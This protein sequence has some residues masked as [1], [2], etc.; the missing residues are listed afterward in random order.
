MAGI[1]GVN[2]V[3]PVVPTSTTDVHPSH[4]ARYGKGGWRTVATVEERDAIPAPRREQGMVVVVAADGRRWVLGS[5]LT[6][7]TEDTGGGGASSW[8]DVT[9]KPTT[10]SGFGITDAVTTA[11]ARLTDSREWTAATVEQAEA[12]AGAA[13]TRRAWTAQRVWQAVAAYIASLAPQTFQVRRG[14]DAE[15]LAIVPASGEPIWTTDGKD[16]YVGDGS[17][18]GGVLPGGINDDVQAAL[19]G[20]ATLSPIY[21]PAAFG[22][23]ESATYLRDHETGNTALHY[24]SDDAYRW[25]VTDP[26]FLRDAISAAPTSHAHGNL[27]SDGKVGSTANLPVITGTA[28]ALTVGSFGTGAN[29]FC[30]GNDAR[31]SDSRTPTAHASTHQPGGADFVAP[32][33]TSPTSLGANQ[34]DYA[35][36]NAD[37]VR[38]TS[39]AAYD[40]TGF[41]A[42]ATARTVLLVNIGSFDLT[43]KHQSTSSTA[44][45][46]IIVPWSADLVIAAGGSVFLWYDLTTARWRAT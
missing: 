6:T 2:V 31:L 7:W 11:D 38:L 36:G 34:N 46:R 18:V 19:A 29:T 14:T 33:V 1:P 17:T 26:E 15:R 40:L 22:A 23:A 4:E 13:T 35:L 37:I 16:L 41:V 27:T 24:D 3:A 5:N 39:G 8:G 44:A 45:N 28:G 21:E 30:V 43:L 20:K 9:G 25:V 42:P 12:E 10:V 32:L